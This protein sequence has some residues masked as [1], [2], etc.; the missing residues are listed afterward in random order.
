MQDS[1]LEFAGGAVG[2]SHAEDSMRF[3]KNVIPCIKRVSFN[4]AEAVSV[5]LRN[6]LDSAVGVNRSH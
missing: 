1:A 4:L 2:Y 5:P 6:R 3:A